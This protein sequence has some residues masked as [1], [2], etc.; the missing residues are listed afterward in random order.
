MSE[1][2]TT[3]ESA[4]LDRL[5]KVVESGVVEI[6]KALA[7]I[8]EKQ[9]FRRDYK[10]WEAYCEGRWR[11]TRQWADLTMKAAKVI[12]AL[13]ETSTVV[14]EPLNA[15]QARELVKLTPE[16]R[17]EV[18]EKLKESGKPVT[19]KAIAETAKA[20]ERDAEPVELK[21]DMG[22]IIPDE[23]RETWLASDAISDRLTELNRLRKWFNND[24]DWDDP[25]WRRAHRQG[26]LSAGETMAM[27]I[28]DAL[29]HCVCLTCNGK[30]VSRCRHCKGTGFLGKLAL[31]T[32][33]KELIALREKAIERQAK[34]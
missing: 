26:I 22:Y 5:E 20:V 34:K 1:Q 24:V 32:T 19:A 18:L 31:T 30:N 7:D 27:E 11:K 25:V 16:H 23:L 4:E 6:G 21:D 8:K 3:S 13:P 2:L 15:R 12:Q 10:T 17:V 9:L 14:D 29:P 28:K 33:P